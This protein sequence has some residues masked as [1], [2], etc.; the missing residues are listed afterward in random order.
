[1][2]EFWRRW[3]EVGRLLLP[4]AADMIIRCAAAGVFARSLPASDSLIRC[5][6][7]ASTRTSSA[8][9]SCPHSVRSSSPAAPPLQSPELLMPS[10]GQSCCF[11][12]EVA[13]LHR[14][15]LA[16]RS[17][18]VVPG[19]VGTLDII[20]EQYW[21]GVPCFPCMCLPCGYLDAIQ[22]GRAVVEPKQRPAALSGIYSE[23]EFQQLRE[24]LRAEVIREWLRSECTPAR[25]G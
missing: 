20:G 5:V 17:K 23:E 2:L 22:P 19:G 14:L 12:D 11:V 10:L 15:D 24:K 25:G 7:S 16:R 9:L 1:M 8:L 21:C 13:Q 3:T 6:C 4:L 18:Q